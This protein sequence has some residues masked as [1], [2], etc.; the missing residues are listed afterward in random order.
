MEFVLYW[1][2]DPFYLKV[3]DK[4]AFQHLAMAFLAVGDSVQLG[5]TYR[6]SRRDSLQAV[7]GESVCSIEVQNW[8]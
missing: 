3:S 5:T 8:I 6:K 1:R 2:G 7:L 4:Y